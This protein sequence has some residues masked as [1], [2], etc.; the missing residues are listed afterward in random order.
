V[1]PVILDT[2]VTYLFII[3]NSFLSFLRAT[4]LYAIARICHDDSVCPSV[5]PSVT[6]VYCIK[7]AERII[8][9]LS[10]SDRTIILVSSFSSPTP[11]GGAKYKGGG[12][13]FRQIC[14]YI[15][16]RV[17]DRGIVTMEDE[18]MYVLY[19]IVLF[20]M[21]LS[22]LEARTLVSSS[23]YSLKTN[24]SQ[25]VH[26]IHSMFG[27]RLGFSGSADRMALFAVR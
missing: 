2:H 3:V 11:N 8:D 17:L 1:T 25:T 23:Q 16:E 7:T 27:S 22:D 20:S 4:A 26:P 5:R 12:I 21:T 14:G 24:I 6:R 13:N 18:Y 9:I 15:S 10:L 19:R